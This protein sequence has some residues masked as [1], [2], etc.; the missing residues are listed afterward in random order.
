MDTEE[1][2]TGQDW[3]VVGATIQRLE[4]HITVIIKL[5][6]G[7]DLSK[8]PPDA[9]GRSLVQAAALTTA[10]KRDTYVKVRA[11]QNLIAIDTYRTTAAE[12]FLHLRQIL[13]LNKQHPILAYKTSGNNTVKGII[14]GIQMSVPDEEIQHELEIQG[15]KVIEAQRIGSSH[16]VLIVMEGTR[17]PRFALYSRV[18]MRLYPYTPR[19][20]FCN[21]CASIGHRADVCPNKLHY[22]RCL[23]CG[24]KLPPD[25]NGISEHNCEI[26]CQNCRGEHP[27]DYPQCPGNPTGPTEDYGITPFEQTDLEGVDV[28]EKN[29]RF[30]A[31]DDASS[32]SHAATKNSVYNTRHAVS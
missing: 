8:L 21:N 22:Q 4:E 18:V 31:A 14:H 32:F 27:A 9:I 2:A 5:T 24:T 3:E 15:T 10:E 19:S 1:I 26:Q 7:T 17:L 6:D 25:P 29:L 20:L 12:K 23:Q 28:S 16:S 30:L 11:I 13:V